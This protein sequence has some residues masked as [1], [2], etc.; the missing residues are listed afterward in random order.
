MSS[1]R[2]WLTIKLPPRWAEPLLAYCDAS[3]EQ[4]ANVVADL[5]AL[6]LDEIEIDQPHVT[7]EQIAAELFEDQV[8][9][10]KGEMGLPQ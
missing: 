5:V 8:T 7:D 6:F 9:A 2:R 3:Y 10:V 1:D 4:P